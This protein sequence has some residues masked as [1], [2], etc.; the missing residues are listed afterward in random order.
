[1]EKSKSSNIIDYL[2]IVA[3]IVIV[4]IAAV[5]D[6]NGT[7][8][9]LGLTVFGVLLMLLGI[10]RRGIFSLIADLISGLF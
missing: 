7:S 1:M 2:L 10:Y 3:G 8:A 4:Y 6:I 5:T 9:G